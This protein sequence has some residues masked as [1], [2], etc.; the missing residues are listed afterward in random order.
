M[1]VLIN[2]GLN[3]STL[4]GWWAE[5]YSTVVGWALGDDH[6]QEDDHATDAADADQLYT[7]LE[8]QVIPEFYDRDDAGIPVSWIH[9]MRESMARLTPQF[10]AVRCVR[11]YTEKHYVPLAGA[12]RAR[13]ADVSRTA[14]QLLSW[15]GQLAEHCH[16]LRFGAIKVETEENQHWFDVQVYLDD[17]D[18]ESIQVELYVDSINGSRCCAACNG[19]WRISARCRK[20]ISLFGIS[21]R[22]APGQRLYAQNRPISS[23]RICAV[24]ICRDSLVSII[25]G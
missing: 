18:P 2:G 17:L 25:V 4:D 22:Y 3:L 13:R 23:C 11:E 15:K 19:A 21:S 1:K 20:C 9:R 14:E 10:S 12:Y 8:Q 7:M 16:K 6:Q 5:A 24:G